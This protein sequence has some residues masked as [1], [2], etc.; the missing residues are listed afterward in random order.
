MPLFH[1]ANRKAEG[2]T[3]TKQSAEHQT[4]EST[5]RSEFF[6]YADSGGQR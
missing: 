5:G 2:A 3:Q 6:K 4:E 1:L